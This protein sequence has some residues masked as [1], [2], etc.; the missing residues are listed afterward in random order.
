MLLGRRFPLNLPAC[1]GS[2]P[3]AWGLLAAA[4]HT[5]RLLQVVRDHPAVRATTWGPL[6]LLEQPQ[7]CAA[8][9]LVAF[10]SHR[11]ILP[12]S[13]LHHVPVQ[14]SPLPVHRPRGPT[15]VAGRPSPSLASSGHLTSPRPQPLRGLCL[16]GGCPSPL[17]SASPFLFPLLARCLAPRLAHSAVAGG[18]CAHSSLPLAP[19]RLLLSLMNAAGSSVAFCFLFC[20]HSVQIPV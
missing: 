18:A 8:P 11:E 2:S 14:D 5:P 16:F 9:S 3:R 17:A 20:S 12:Q 15:A 7:L 10:T 1:P 19:L 6:A 4:G 13:F